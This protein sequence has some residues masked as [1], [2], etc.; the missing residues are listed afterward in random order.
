MLRRFSV[1]VTEHPAESL[2]AAHAPDSPCGAGQGRDDRVAESLVIPL[3]V[4]MGDV[5]AN[6]AS[7]E[8]FA[9]EDHSV[10][11][12][13]LD[14]PHEPLDPCVGRSCR[15]HPITTIRI[16]VS[17]SRIGSTRCSGASTIS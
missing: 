1:V 13:R 8:V 14:R 16:I 2:T 9:K 5:L 10:E 11:A 6:C 15:V 4:V 17:E 3:S 12:L 7:Q